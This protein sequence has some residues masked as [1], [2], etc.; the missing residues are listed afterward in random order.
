MCQFLEGNYQVPG[1]SMIISTRG[2][3][4]KLQDWTKSHTVKI[5]QCYRDMIRVIK[6]LLK[7]VTEIHILLSYSHLVSVCSTAPMT[8]TELV[9]I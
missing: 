1:V 3:V 7:L 8:E 9:L 2:N 5:F 6:V 4:L